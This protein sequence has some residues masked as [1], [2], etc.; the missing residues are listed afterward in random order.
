VSFHSVIN[1]HK[2]SF[3]GVDNK[4]AVKIHSNAALGGFNVWL[5]ERW[6]HYNCDFTIVKSPSEYEVTESFSERHE[7][8]LFLHYMMYFE[9]LLRNDAC[10]DGFEILL[11][12]HVLTWIFDLCSSHQRTWV[13]E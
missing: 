9:I 4:F 6:C 8:R 13:L 1:L 12:T 3:Y 7:C 5:G 2:L 11:G 10:L